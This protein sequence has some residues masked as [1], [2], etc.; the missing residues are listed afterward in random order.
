[1][2]SD[3][4]PLYLLSNVIPT[5]CTE[6]C[7]R[8]QLFFLL[9]LFYIIYFNQYPSYRVVLNFFFEYRVIDSN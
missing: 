4:F 3:G 1:M 5:L 2:L 9:N 6:M 8:V 7:N